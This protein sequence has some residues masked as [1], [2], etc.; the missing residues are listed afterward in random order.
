MPRHEAFY[1]LTTNCP[2]AGRVA[3]YLKL[4]N[5]RPDRQ[6]H[7]A[8]HVFHYPL[9]Y[10]L[11]QQVPEAQNDKHNSDS[12]ENP[13]GFLYFCSA[14]V[15]FLVPAVRK[16]ETRGGTVGCNLEPL[17]KHLDCSNHL[18]MRQDFLFNS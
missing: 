7:P 4:Q 5:S 11:P 3:S 1:T 10:F 6:A 18:S 2:T 15:V 17:P 14:F 13:S 9:M 12:R 16:T 8:S